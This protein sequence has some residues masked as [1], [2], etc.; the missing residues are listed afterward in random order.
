MKFFFGA[1][2]LLQAHLLLFDVKS[3]H[4]LKN[5]VL[6]SKELP[7]HPRTTRYDHHREKLE[8]LE[9]IFE[10][11]QDEGSNKEKYTSE[12]LRAWA[13]LLQ[14]KKHESYE[15]PPDKPF[16]RNTRQGKKSHP[17][18]LAQQNSGMPSDSVVGFISWEAS[19]AAGPVN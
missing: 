10:K 15:K 7:R 17:R 13:H 16:F 4:I 8:E 14:M 18:E 3:V 11:L 1:I 12:Q 6:I 2:R 5:R 9:E 19:S